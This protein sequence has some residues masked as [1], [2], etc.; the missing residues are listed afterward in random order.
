MRRA[1]S[2]PCR[3][4]QKRVDDLEAQLAADRALGY[5]DKHPDIQ[6]LQREIKQ[7]RADLTAAKTQQ[8]ANSEET[9][10]RTR[11]TAPRS[12]SGTWRGCTSREL[13][14]ALRRGTAADRR[15]PEAASS[16][17]R[18]LEQELASLDREYAL[19]KARY[20]DLSS[21]F[22]NAR[23]A[24]DVA[25]KQGGERFSILYPASLPTDP[26]S[27]NRCGSWPSRW[28]PASC[29]APRRRSAASSSTAPSTTRAPWRTNSKSRSS[30]RFPGSPS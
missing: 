19:E 2:P 11:C 15:V 29:S 4:A 22:G 14:S 16:P 27:R 17:R 18:S 20:A 6:R 26:S 7:A 21:R 5:T 28:S 9:L 3:P 30:A 8:P 24:E 23:I 25:R 10:R 12:R 1:R 13:Q